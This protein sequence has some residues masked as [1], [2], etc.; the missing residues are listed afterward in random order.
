MPS[1]W[2]LPI[3]TAGTLQI[4][5]STGLSRQA[6]CEKNFNFPAPPFNNISGICQN[7]ADTWPAV[8]RVLSRG[9]ERTLGTRLVQLRKSAIHGLPVPLRMLRVKSDKSDWF[10]SQYIVFTQ[11]FKTGMSLDLARG[12]DISSA[13]QK[14]PLWTRLL[15]EPLVVAIV[16]SK[17]ILPELSFSGLWSRGTKLWERDCC[18]RWSF[19]KWTGRPKPFTLN[20]WCSEDDG[21]N[22]LLA[23]FPYIHI[24]RLSVSGLIAFVDYYCVRRTQS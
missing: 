8:T 13:W 7:L 10:S 3:H 21:Q 19:A 20:D 14:G 18:Q 5:L 15:Q 9:R 6:Q 12:P 1:L 2:L 4:S 11:P 16:I 17:W 24:I 22:S 23:F